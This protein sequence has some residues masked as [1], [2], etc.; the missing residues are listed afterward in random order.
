MDPEIFRISAIIDWEY[1]GFWPESFEMPLWR[2]AGP[3]GAL[4]EYGGLNDTERF[5]GLVKGVGC[6]FR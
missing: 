2:R 6:G 1:A 3:S 4:E 5:S